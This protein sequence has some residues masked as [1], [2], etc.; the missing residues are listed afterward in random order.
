M[1]ID[2]PTVDLEDLVTLSISG[3]IGLGY[4]NGNVQKANNLW[5][6]DQDLSIVKGNHELKFGFN[7]MSTRFAFL[8]PAHPNG[9]MTFN[10]SYTGNGLA[11][12]LYGRPISSQ[13]D[14]R[15]FF[16]M[17]RF[18]PSFYVQDNWRATAKLTL[19]LG[20]RDD[21]VTPWRERDNWLAGSDLRSGAG[22]L[23]PVGHAFR[24]GHDHRRPVYRTSPR[25]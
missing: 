17:L 7:W 14:V 9:T 25:A 18:C 16:S 15:K 6:F 10:G 22:N 1:R 2:R 24:W 3:I 8:T 5:E 13:L 4:G 11:D 12:F 19:N 23:V 21:L 20:L